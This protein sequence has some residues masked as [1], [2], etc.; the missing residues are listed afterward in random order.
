MTVRRSQGFYHACPSGIYS[1]PG[2][3]FHQGGHGSQGE[4]YMDR[5]DGPRVQHSE[6]DYAN[7][8]KSHTI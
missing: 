1:G 2:D 8:D 4:V 7:K 6:E 5:H 3:P